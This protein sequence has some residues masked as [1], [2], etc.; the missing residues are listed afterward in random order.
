MH[1]ISAAELAANEERSERNRPP[2]QLPPPP[3]AKPQRSWQDKVETP[4]LFSK[5]SDVEAS[6]WSSKSRNPRAEP[7]LRNNTEQVASTHGIDDP[8]PP[9]IDLAVF[10]SVVAIRKLLDDAQDLVL[11]VASGMSGAAMNSMN[12]GLNAFVNGTTSSAK[13]TAMALGLSIGPSGEVL[14]GAGRGSTMSSA[15]AHKLR[16]LAVHK[17]AEAYRIDEIVASVMIMQGASPLEDLAE[18]VLKVGERIQVYLPLRYQPDHFIHQDPKSADA[19]Y[20]HFFHEKIPV[21]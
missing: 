21:R 18:R 17:V 8:L 16:V 6:F 20:V 3:L 7:S 1:T 12:A 14:G 10:S 2:K 9:P 4:T 11:R 13:A 19:R 15:R 5:H